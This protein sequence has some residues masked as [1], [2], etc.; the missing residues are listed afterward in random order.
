MQINSAEVSSFGI[1]SRGQRETSYL[2]Q[3]LAGYKSNEELVSFHIC[4]K[5]T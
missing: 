1:L 2:D 4:P 3:V 5:L